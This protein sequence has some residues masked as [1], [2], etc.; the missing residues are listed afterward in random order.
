[1][2]LV[3]RGNTEQGIGTV[4]REEG[5]APFG[6]VS[7]S[8]PGPASISIGA[9]I[10]N[11][12]GVVHRTQ[13]HGPAREL[14]LG[15]FVERVDTELG[16]KL[17]VPSPGGPIV[18]WW[19]STRDKVELLSESDIVLVTGSGVG[20]KEATFGF[21]S[22]SWNTIDVLGENSKRGLRLVLHMMTK[23]I[24]PYGDNAITL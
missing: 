4:H 10:H 8:N 11:L 17:F 12:A 14:K 13:S 16:S 3:G 7:E 1:M 9:T 15:S 6:W 24:S 22:I 18:R 20:K 2:L 19:G 5:S 21:Q 23:F